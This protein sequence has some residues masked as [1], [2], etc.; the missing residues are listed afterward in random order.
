MLPSWCDVRLE[1]LEYADLPTVS[2][3][4]FL[5]LSW[6]ASVSANWTLTTYHSQYSSPA[7]REIHPCIL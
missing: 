4:S 6:L 5:S 2:T 7:H 1:E 3:L